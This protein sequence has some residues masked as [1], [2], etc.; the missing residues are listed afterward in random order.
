MQLVPKQF[1]H[2]QTTKHF[3]E[4]AS[5]ATS[6]SASFAAPGTGLLY[7]PI[8]CWTTASAVA[9]LTYYNGTGGS[10]IFCV[11]TQAGGTWDFSFWE[12]PGNMTA[13]KCPV[14]ES[15]AG[16]GVHEFHVY[17][18]V[19]RSAAGAGATVQ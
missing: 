4:G 7:I 2:D 18:I 16:V 11:K 9:S 10:A 3:S 14:L 5:L 12:E 17:A 19:V 1:Y 13:N 8:Y 6:G 15:N